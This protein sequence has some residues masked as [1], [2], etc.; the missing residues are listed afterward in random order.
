MKSVKA[1]RNTKLVKG[2]RKLKASSSNGLIMPKGKQKG[3]RSPYVR[4]PTVMLSHRGKNTWQ[5][6]KGPAG[7][8][9]Y[10]RND[11]VIWQDIMTNVEAFF[12]LC[13]GLGCLL[14]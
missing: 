8:S 9:H 10:S 3:Q 11:R 1:H 14:Q 4:K 7:S 2:P 6:Q 13:I 5:A 12:V